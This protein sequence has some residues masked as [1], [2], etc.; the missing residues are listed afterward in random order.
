MTQSRFSLLPISLKAKTLITIAL[1]MSVIIGISDQIDLQRNHEQRAELLTSR[2]SLAAQIQADALDHP[3]WDLANEQ[4]KSLLG[5]L[6]RD[7]DFLAAEVIGLD[8]KSVASLGDMEARSGFIETKTDVKHGEGS[9]QKTIGQLVLRLSTAG[10]ESVSRQQFARSICIMLLIL[11]MLMVAIWAA[12]R[13]ITAPLDKMTRVMQRL[14]EGDTAL[15]VPS[16]NRRDEI[17]AMARAVSVFKTNAMDRFRLESEQVTIKQQAEADRRQSL[18]KLGDVIEGAVNGIVQTVSG[19]S[20]ELERTAISMTSGAQKMDGQVALISNASEQ[21]SVN[22]QTVATAAEQLSCSIE[23]ISRQTAQSAE[24][25]GQAVSQTN[26]TNTSV[27]SLV[28]TA[29]KIGDV[30]KL[31]HDIAG[32]TNLLALNAT[33]EAARAGEAGKGF[34]VV[35]AEVKSL[36][37]QTANATEEITTQVS[38]IQAATDEAVRSI[39]AISQTI[40]QINNITTGIAAA[41]EEQSAATREI[42]RNV[43]AAADSTR[44]VST[45]ITGIEAAVRDNNAAAGVVRDAS[46]LLGHQLKQMTGEFGEMVVRIRAA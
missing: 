28:A 3:M 17:G 25:A 13:L 12:L 31:I 18:G 42:S 21:A 36:A 4:V 27:Q 32:Q 6:A 19:A 37:T 2:A 23:E 44:T 33:I 24:V 45:N 39:S 40:G 29:R 1:L 46:S 35:A 16:L 15:E 26:Q 38:A 34:A 5:G 7:P 14:A 9:K 20:Q 8:G 30:V 11:G 43:Q 10:L 22:V 41:I